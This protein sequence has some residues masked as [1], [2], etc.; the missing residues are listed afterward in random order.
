MTS[1]QNPCPY[2]KRWF[3]TMEVC[4]PKKLWNICMGTTADNR[5]PRRPWGSRWCSPRRLCR[6]D[7]RIG[8]AVHA[9]IFCNCRCHVD[10]RCF[11]NTW[12]RRG[13]QVGR[14]I[15]HCGGAVAAILS[16]WQLLFFGEVLKRLECASRAQKRTTIERN[17][18]GFRQDL[19]HSLRLHR[20]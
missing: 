5:R 20:S 4:I 11:G 7:R 16:S 2:R 18:L 3:Q 17:K 9:L 19:G 8:L 10:R 1:Q 15:E 12:Q 6:S 13:G 14:G